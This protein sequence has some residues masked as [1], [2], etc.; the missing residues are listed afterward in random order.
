MID[1]TKLPTELIYVEFTDYKDVARAIKNLVIRGAPAI[2]VAGA[3]G[4]ALAALQSTAKTTNE[5]IQDLE[6]AKKILFETRPTAVN[7]SWGLEQI[8][9]TAKQGH[10]VSEIQESVV[11]TAKQMAD[12]DIKINRTMGKHGSKLF[13]NNDIIMTHCNAGALATVA[14]GTALGVI[15]ATKE[16][17]KNIKVIATETRP[18]QQG[19]RLTAFELQHDGIDVSLIPDT[20]VGYTMAKHLVNKVIVGAD[21]IL[22]TGHVFNKIGTYQVA[23]IAKQHGI[24]F[25][26]AAPLSSFD[27][28]SNVEDVV[29]EQR[30]ADELTSIGGKKTAPDN[31]NV[32]NPAFDMTPPEFIAGI[33]TEV[34][35]AKPPFEASIKKLFEANK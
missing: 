17:G 28:K 4:L 16:S 9:K 27:L 19:S 5:L 23:L 33:I 31:I 30:K 15:R 11:H 6:T 10:T 22:R 35:I 2:G 14:Y 12:D 13:D 7:L 34:G 29:I 24:P 26:V 20:A 25:Y 32:L 18:V 1:Q 8:M 21:R 3:F